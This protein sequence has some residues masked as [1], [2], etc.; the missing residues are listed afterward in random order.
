MSGMNWQHIQSRWSEYQLNAKRRWNRLSAEDLQ[1]IAG[2]RERLVAK[3]AER[4]TIAPA[5]AEQELAA[6]LA[7]LRDDNPFG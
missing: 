7:A 3:I 4:Y 6:W 5:Q 2:D 1:A